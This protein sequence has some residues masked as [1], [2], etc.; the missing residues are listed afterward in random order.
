MHQCLSSV[1]P[2]GSRTPLVITMGTTMG[3]LI[4]T[5]LGTTMGINL[6]GILNTMRPIIGIGVHLP[7][8]T[9]NKMK[10]TIGAH[11]P[12]GT[13]NKMRAIIGVNRTIKKMRAIIEV[14]LPLGNTRATPATSKH[15]WSRNHM[16]SWTHHRRSRTIRSTRIRWHA[17]ERRNSPNTQIRSTPTTARASAEQS[18]IVVM[19]TSHRRW[20]PRNPLWWTRPPRRTS[21]IRMGSAHSTPSV[22]VGRPTG[23]VRRP[24]SSHVRISTRVSSPTSRT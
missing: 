1:T 20:W 21:M 11:L 2:M 7:W 18:S 17:G 3:I 12:L 6:Q 10:A 22:I 13:L 14:H 4:I 16:I 9:F 15:Q 19:S 5:R 24:A 8:G 23:I